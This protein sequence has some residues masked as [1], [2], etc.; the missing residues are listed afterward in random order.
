MAIAVSVLA[1]ALLVGESVRATLRQLVYQRLG[2]T[3]QVFSSPTFFREGL[4]GQFGSAAPVIGLE[5]TVDSAQGGRRAAKVQVWGVDERFWRFHGLQERKL[6]IRETLAS[7]ALAQELGLGPEDAILLTLEKP[8]AVPLD[9]LHG[10]KEQASRTIR[11]KF[12]GILPAEELGEF[13]LRPAQGAVRALFVPLARLQRDLER[14][15]RVNIALLAEPVGGGPVK[16]R[17]E[18]EDLGIRL[19]PLDASRGFAVESESMI[20]SDTLAAAVASAAK[21]TGA[22]SSPVYTYLA[23]SIRVNGREIPY[24]LV[25]GLDGVP[26]SSDGI[27]LNEWAA[28]DLKAKPGEHVRLDFYL[29]HPD[30]RLLTE[31]ATLRLEGILPMTGLGGDR[32][33]A[34]EYPGLTDS[35]SIS[36]WDPPFPIDL[37]R[38]RPQ[39][40]AYWERYRAAPK[41]FIALSRARQ[42]WP[43]RYGQLTSIRVSGTRPEEFTSALMGVIDPA[44]FGLS[45]E[46]PREE[47]L[48]SAT[49]ST[50]FG[51]YF[52]YF[53]FFLVVAALL[54]AGLF[55]RFGV[56]QRLREIGTLRA[57][58]FT[59]GTIRMLFL[60]EGAV[61]AI[62]GALAGLLGSIAYASLIVYGLRTWWVGAVGTTLLSLHVTAQPLLLGALGGAAS[63]VVFLMASLRQ[64]Q[65]SSPRSLT[66]GVASSPETLPRVRKTTLWAGW[67]AG[68]TALA[69]IAAAAAGFIGQ[70]AG[71]FGA[72]GLLLIAT[73]CFVANLLRR[74][75]EQPMSDTVRLG[76]RYTAY[77]PG[78][79][80]LSIALIALAAFII[81]SVDSFRRAGLDAE[82]RQSGTGG[83]SLMAESS[84]PLFYSLN[85]PDGRARLNLPSEVEN[86]RTFS[87]KVR[88]G[89]DASCLNL[90]RPRNPKVVAPPRELMLEKRFGFSDSLAKDEQSEQNPWLLLDSPVVD[91]SIPAIADA[92]SLRYTLQRKLGDVMELPGGVRLRF[93]ATLA[94]SIFQSEIIVSPEN[95]ARVFPHEAGFQL[96]LLDAPAESAPAAAE[97]YERALADY[98]FDVTSTRDRL[99][100]FHRVENTYLSTFQTLGGLGLLLGTAGLGVVL[101]RNVLERRRELALLRAVGYGAGSLR[102][103]LL[104]ESVLLLVTG[105]A[106]GAVCALVAIAPAWWERGGRLPLASLAM[107]LGSVLLAGLMSSAL[108]LRSVRRSPILSA[109]RSE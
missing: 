40:E 96:F 56:E 35:E 104:S 23:N 49:G 88:A 87:F 105:L 74:R 5:G 41:A 98:G 93:V 42:L 79:S 102:V 65:R 28:R 52:T 106:T 108:A 71:F 107:L 99:A 10:H 86:V 94:D 31:S 15:G 85:S 44:A 8:S 97:A 72:G 24:S 3:R 62:A 58:G 77:R 45:L 73:L 92:N 22:V 34:P 38:I 54:L 103:V 83:F 101:L 67:G 109:L 59:P 20:L 17:L 14:P 63:A 37:S 51:E 2:E 91:G 33:L 4:A 50:D 64:L 81:V 30:G 43:T 84:V 89:E 69:L 1:G 11:L 6:E 66:A 55:F 95:F 82:D 61:I 19:R 76:F 9:S 47:G 16:Q 53:S 12:G 21:T 48:A 13:A 32:E 7:E 90:Y 26:V 68:L 18:P 39:D 46:N 57:L 25:S 29:W 75:P 78:R 27:L 100:A 60:M 80:I 70:T 36:D